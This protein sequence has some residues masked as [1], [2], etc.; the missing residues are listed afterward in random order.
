LNGAFWRIIPTDGR[1]HREDA[2]EGAFGDSVGH[3]EGDKLVIE[4]IGFNE[5]T[6]L[7]DNGAFHT[8]DMKVIE[9]LSMVGGKIDYKLTVQDPAV[10]VEP[11]VKQAKLSTTKDPMQPV[12]CVE[13]SIGKMTG[14][15][16]YHPNPRW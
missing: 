4:S 10:L 8:G 9:E 1:G 13:M 7:T 3:W 5:D 14:I 2:E 11:W 6:W 15:E 12:P 16:S